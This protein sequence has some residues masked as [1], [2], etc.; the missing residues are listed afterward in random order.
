MRQF[1]RT[2]LGLE[3]NVKI[4]LKQIS[5]DNPGLEHGVGGLNTTMH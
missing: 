3:D 1:G 4:D 5:W 2:T